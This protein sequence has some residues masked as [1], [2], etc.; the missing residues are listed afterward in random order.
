MIQWDVWLARF[1]YDDSDTFD[2]KRP[3]IVLNIE[4]LEVLAIKVT[5]H[6]LREEDIYDTPILKWREAG[7][8]S[9]SVARVSKTVDIPIDK[10]I[11]KIG[12][13]D[14]ED[15]I[16]ILGKASEFDKQKLT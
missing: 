6:S 12:E 10:F 3:V 1:P 7:L 14:I 13:I 16:I 9:P 5:S 4:P 8:R 11:H 2:K 15:R